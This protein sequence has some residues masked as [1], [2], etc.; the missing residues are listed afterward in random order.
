META[1][2]LKVDNETIQFAFQAASV[3]ILSTGVKE[4]THQANSKK[5]FGWV[6]YRRRTYTKT[7]IEVK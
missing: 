1:R 2:Y 4:Y 6:Q 5:V 7:D 3:K